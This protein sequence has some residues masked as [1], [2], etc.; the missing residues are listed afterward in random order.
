MAFYDDV[1]INISKEFSVQV[2]LINRILIVTGEGEINDGNGGFLKVSGNGA[3]EEFEKWLTDNA[4]TAPKALEAVTVAT[5]QTD[6]SGN[7]IMPDVIYVV[8]KTVA[9]WA[10]AGDVAPLTTLIETNTNVES[11]YWAVVMTEY[12]KTMNEWAAEFCGTNRKGFYTEINDKAYVPID[13]EKSDRSYFIY[14]GQ[15]VV[16]DK[17]DRSTE[18]F[19]AAIAG[20]TIIPAKL[21]A[22]KMKTVKGITSYTTNELSAAEALTLATNG[23]NTY[24]KRWGKGMLDGS[25]TSDSDGTQKSVNHI[26]SMFIRD[27]IVY[28]LRKNVY[29]WL[30]ESE[31]ASMEDYPELESVCNS[32][33][34]FFAD[35]GFI[36]TDT[37]T[38]KQQF[39]VNVPVP[40]S[41][42]RKERL[43]KA[44]FKYMPNSAVEWVTITGQEIFD[45][46]GG[47]L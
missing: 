46:I 14:N 41:Q 13:L 37:E 33:L 4:V 36:A 3:K 26:D 29:L 7:P 9:D 47:E 32:V 34:K 2:G 17:Y 12:A 10:S 38:Q 18:Q 28:N 40:S 16:V 44:T 45:L 1:I 5:T 24:L 11:D 15:E 31:F 35:S 23:V 39:E 6:S 22:L 42:D 30:N 21:T 8:G 19:P 43:M 20:R 27:N 25:F